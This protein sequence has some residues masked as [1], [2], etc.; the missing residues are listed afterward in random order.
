[1]SVKVHK[2]GSTIVCVCVCV[3]G[4][5]RDPP[6]ELPGVILGM[7]GL[8]EIKSRD[9]KWRGKKGTGHFKPI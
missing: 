8:M 4:R 7:G 3:W 1:M 2:G 6:V 5:F 9:R